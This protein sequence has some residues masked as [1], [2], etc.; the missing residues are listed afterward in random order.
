[1][2]II[3]G[4][5][6]DSVSDNYT[7]LELDT[8]LVAGKTYTAYCLV[9]NIPLIEFSFLESNKKLHAELIT[10]YQQR[11]WSFCKDAIEKLLGLW[12]GSVDTF[13]R[14][15][16]SRIADYEQNP[17]PPQWNGVLQQ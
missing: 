8:V 1:M 3:F 11:N 9:D 2:N 12:G 15:L 4:D 16:Q 10:Q 13:Y 17:P 6:I 14:E 7:K 5:A